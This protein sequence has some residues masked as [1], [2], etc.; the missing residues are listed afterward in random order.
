MDYEKNDF[1]PKPQ[2]RILPLRGAATVR[3]SHPYKERKATSSLTRKYCNIGGRVGD[4]RKN[5]T[6]E[7]RPVKR[8]N[9]PVATDPNAE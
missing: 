4:G 2:C 8:P 6:P 3:T 7:T 5:Q 1:K 9:F